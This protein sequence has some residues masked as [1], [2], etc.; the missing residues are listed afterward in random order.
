MQLYGE[1]RRIFS[2]HTPL[3]FLVFFW[4]WI[5]E[6]EFLLT[7]VR[8]APSYWH[9]LYLCLAHQNIE[10][11]LYSPPLLEDCP[12]PTDLCSDVVQCCERCCK[13]SL[14]LLSL[15]E[16]HLCEFPLECAS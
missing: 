16:S 4:P 1:S 6:I 8:A 10:F 11:H 15:S 12:K 2:Y 14:I 5:M 13:G 9:S 7:V 3:F